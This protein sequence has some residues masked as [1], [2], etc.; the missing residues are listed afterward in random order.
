MTAVSFALCILCLVSLSVVVVAAAAQQDDFISL[1]LIPHHVQRAR[2]N[3]DYSNT[4]NEEKEEEEEVFRSHYPRRRRRRRHLQQ[5][6]LTIG[7]LYQGYGTHYVLRN[8][9]QSL[10]IP[11]V[12]SLPFRVRDAPTI[13]EPTTTWTPFFKNL[14]PSRFTN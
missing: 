9:K 3:L 1:A 2:R 11:A 7:A 5:D 10:S 14:V 13:A 12:A 4:F 8:D 6:T